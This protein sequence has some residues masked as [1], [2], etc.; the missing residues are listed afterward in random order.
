MPEVEALPPAP[1]PAT[2]TGAQ[3]RALRGLGH[4][5][6]PVVQLGKAGVTEGL[7]EATNVALLQHELI[8]ISIG[9]ESP[10]D[11]KTAPD[12]LARATGAHVAQVI[13]YTALLYRRRL[14]APTIVLPGPAA[15]VKSPAPAST[16][17]PAAPLPRIRGGVRP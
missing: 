6:S 1:S 12:E 13:G 14:E 8:K 2:L 3:R 7:V 10:V 9:R 17:K 5:L 16:K 15:P 4:H 11:R